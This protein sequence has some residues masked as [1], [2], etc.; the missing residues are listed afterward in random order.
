MALLLNIVGK[1]GVELYKT[2]NLSK[3]SKNNL[4]VVLQYFEEYCIPMKN[5][6]Y[7]SFKFFN[8]IQL[9]GE[10]FEREKFEVF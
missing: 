1:E 7:E 9:G 8:R 2:F 4:A 10:K 3:E 6:V 5:I